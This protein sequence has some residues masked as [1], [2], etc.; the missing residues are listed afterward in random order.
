MKIKSLCAVPLVDK[1]QGHPLLVIQLA[2]N[3]LVLLLESFTL[4]DKG[5]LLV[6][7]ALLDAAHNYRV[8]LAL[9]LLQVLTLKLGPPVYQLLPLHL[10]VVNLN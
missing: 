7:G 3:V 5:K 1:L 2:Q 8:A 10:D 9:M 6:F 4:G